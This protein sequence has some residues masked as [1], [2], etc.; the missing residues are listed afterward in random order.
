MTATVPTRPAAREDAP[1][2]VRVC[3]LTQLDPERGVAVL[4]G[5]WQIAL[6][7]THTDE[8]YAVDNQDPFSGAM[9]M[10]RGI[11]GTRKSAPTVAS[12]MYKQVFDLRT[13]QCLDDPDVSLG[14]YRTRVVAGAVEVSI[15]GTFDGAHS[16]TDPT[17]RGA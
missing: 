5:T 17:V 13:G 11:V 6:F 9:V 3:S 4:I 16:A 10:S 12:P 8:L 15:Q 14:T 2:W 1:E 7:R